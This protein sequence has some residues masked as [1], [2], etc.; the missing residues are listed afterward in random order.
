M[1]LAAEAAKQPLDW[2]CWSMQPRMSRSSSSEAIT[3]V[4]CYF[5]PAT[6]T[7]YGAQPIRSSRTFATR[8]PT[9]PSRAGLRK[10]S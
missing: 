4:Q 7:G 5:P 3:R 10:R 2:M 8:S 6:T 9:K 1:R